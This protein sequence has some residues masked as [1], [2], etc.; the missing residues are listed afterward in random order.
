M[1]I[2]PAVATNPNPMPEVTTIEVYDCSNLSLLHIPPCLDI[3]EITIHKNKKCLIGV[4][5]WCTHMW[6]DRGRIYHE[7]NA[8]MGRWVYCELSNSNGTIIQKKVGIRP[9]FIKNP[10]YTNYITPDQFIFL[11]N[12]NPIMF[13]LGKLPVG[14][15]TLKAF[16]NGN[17]KDNLPRSEK[18]VKIHV[19]P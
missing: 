7:S 8:M 1:S 10:F 11:E 14:E 18:L 15:Y 12:L 4:H 16:Y 6:T 2:T 3:D 5:L 19:I 13:S 17:K 9:V